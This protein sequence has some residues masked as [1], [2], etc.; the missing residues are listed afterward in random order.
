[1]VII[2]MCRPTLTDVAVT[3]HL[4]EAG[5]LAARGRGQGGRQLVEVQFPDVQRDIGS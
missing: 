4:E 2:N 3:Q 1:M 5:L